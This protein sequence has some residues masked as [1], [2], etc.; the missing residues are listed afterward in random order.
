MLPLFELSIAF[1][2]GTKPLGMRRAIMINIF[3]VSAFQW[4]ITRLNS[5]ASNRYPGLSD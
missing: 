5:F 4:K 2:Q 1:E 3:T